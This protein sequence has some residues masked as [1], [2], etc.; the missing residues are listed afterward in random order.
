MSRRI[1]EKTLDICYN[2]DYLV[3]VPLKDKHLFDDIA[4]TLG[5]ALLFENSV[6]DTEFLI[7]FLKSNTIGQLI[8]VDY[9]IEY[10]EIISTLVDEHSIKFVFT[11]SL[12]ELSN[13]Y[14]LNDF[15]KICEKYE[16]GV[17]ESIGLL[18]RYLYEAMRLRHRKVEMVLLDTI[19]SEGSKKA[20]NTI[21]LM[22]AGDSDYC[23]FYNEMSCMSLLP[24]YTLK[25]YYPV[26]EA[27]KFADNYGIKYKAVG[28]LV[29]LVSGNIC[30]LDVNFASGL[31]LNFMK[32]MDRGIPCVVGNNGFLTKDYPVMNECLVV[33]SDDDINE[34]TEKVKGAISNREKILKEYKGFRVEY[35]KKAK[36]LTSKF[37]GFNSVIRREVEYE[38]ILTVVVPVYNTEKYLAG[39][40]DSIIEAMVSDMEILVIDD[41]STD[42]SEKVIKK[43]AEKY[44]NLIRHIRQKNRGLGNVRNVGL[45]EAKGKYIASVDSDDTIESEFLKDALPYLRE[46]VDAVICD[47]MS[48]AEDKKFETVALD[49]VFSGRKTMEGLLYTTIMPSTCNKIIKKGLF[50][51]DGIEY[52]EQKYEDLSANPLVLLKA[53]TVKYIHKPYYNYYLRSN[54]LMRS[55]ID[56]R[57]MVD[58]LLYLD[59]RL[60][61]TNEAINVEEFKYFTYSWRIE[62]YILNPL[63]ELNGKELEEA[64][65]HIYKN[66]YELIKD[67]FESKYYKKMLRELSSKELKEYIK[68]RNKAFAEKRLKGFILGVK[69]PQKLTAGIIYYGDC[70]NLS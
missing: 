3:I 7:Q 35:S 5:N 64:I 51:D 20:S 67:V 48:L 21:G 13:E 8:F 69:E 54:S 42:G 53:E 2:L 46:D 57:E 62:E 10:D 12:G 33:Q 40:L 15:E 30:N 43:Y 11:K 61:I 34:I 24:Q 36:E 19:E 66:V 31:A 26:K 56:P 70:M 14:V 63:Y 55:K 18:D 32:S 29:E 59:K 47:W 41:G 44:P 37:L 1:I 27:I 9:Y 49:Q 17:V 52:L 60:A 25:M 16:R 38:K 6:E 50:V 68:T 23:S 4:F 58:A 39:C 65:E 45:K 28:D 22:G